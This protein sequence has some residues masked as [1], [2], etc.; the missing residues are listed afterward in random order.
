MALSHFSVPSTTPLPQVPEQSESVAAVQPTGQHCSDGPQAVMNVCAQ[1]AEHCAA[2]PSMLSAV[3]GLWSSQSVA[4]GQ[5]PAV[6]GG[7]AGS[8]ISL[9][10]IMP[11]PSCG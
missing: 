6:G 9:A 7:I 8:H 10:S 1:R 2:L 4:V 5:A 3:H 11:F